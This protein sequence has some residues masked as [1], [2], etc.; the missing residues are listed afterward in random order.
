MALCPIVLLGSEET[1]N[2]VLEIFNILGSICSLATLI[3]ALLLY[4]KLTSDQH[5]LDKQMETV[6]RLISM[7]RSL[8]FS[9]ETENKMGVNINFARFD[10]KRRYP[11]SETPLLVNHSYIEYISGVLKF[12]NSHFLPK[13]IA[14]AINKVDLAMTGQPNPNKRYNKLNHGMESI[15]FLKTISVLS[16]HQL[17]SYIERIK[18]KSTK[19]GTFNGKDITV[20]EFVGYWHDLIES[21]LKWLKQNKPSIKY[22]LPNHNP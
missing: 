22:N 19:W 16:P 21:I 9:V 11:I 20:N 18:D 14:L 6:E 1:D 5:A 2:S 3:I 10:P 12:Y 13:E 4:N 15:E 17:E 7:I 8:E